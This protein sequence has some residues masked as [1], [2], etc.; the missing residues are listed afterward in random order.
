VEKI[1][2]VRY[3]PL[4]LDVPP[5]EFRRLSVDEVEKLKT[6]SGGAALG[7]VGRSEKG[8]DPKKMRSP[9]TSKAFNRKE[10]M[11]SP[12]KSKAFNRKERKG[13]KEKH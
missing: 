8:F 13:R 6:G 12:A 4:K 2:R 3:G 7:S 5:G 1:K 9:T 10:K 11:R